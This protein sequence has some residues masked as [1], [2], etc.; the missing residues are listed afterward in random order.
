[1]AKARNIIILS[2]KCSG[3]S[4]CQNILGKLAD[5]RLIS[6]TRHRYNETLYW[7]KAAS[8]LGLPQLKMI[9]SEVP[10]SRDKA[11]AD[12][13]A[14]LRA[15]LADFEAPRDDRELIFGGWRMLC[16]KYS[17]I[18][19]EKSPHHLLQWSA[20]Q[21]ILEFIETTHDIDVLIIGLIR[22]PMDTIYCHWSRWRSEPETVERQ[23]VVAYK[24]LQNLK[25][26]CGN[27]LAIVRYEDMV[28]SPDSLTPAL[29]VIGL[30]PDHAFR[31]EL[32]ER[33]LCRWKGDRWF[34]FSL[35]GSAVQLAE[36]YGYQAKDLDNTPRLLWPVAR[37]LSTA[38]YRLG[39]A[40]VRFARNVAS[41]RR[42]AS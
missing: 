4:A 33:S 21:L 28:T 38:R 7:T 14:L 29:E 25:D 41:R 13:V 18:F 32:H 16:E 39:T 34:G 27:R 10:I 40:A 8:I 24:N 35:S 37:R 9:D 31:G 2:E 20:L 36:S 22:N 42:S 26:I 1:M 30:R 15:N 23:W 11:R 12:L 6:T 17:P 5:V 3:S 19:L